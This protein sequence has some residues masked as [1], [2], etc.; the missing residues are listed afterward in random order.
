M[1]CPRRLRRLVADLSSGGTHFLPLPVTR[2][3]TIPTLRLADPK[4]ASSR[5]STFHLRVHLEERGTADSTSFPIDLP[6]VPPQLQLILLEG[7]GFNLE[8]KEEWK[9]NGAKK[10]VAPPIRSREKGGVHHPNIG[11]TTPPPNALL[12]LVGS[13]SLRQTRSLSP[14][15]SS[16]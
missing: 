13:P 4:M 6:P 1:S 5:K 3:R 11:C 15:H 9:M 2:T 7:P 8:L 16:R 10:L 12:N 14:T